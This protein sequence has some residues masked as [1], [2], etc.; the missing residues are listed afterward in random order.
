MKKMMLALWL[1]AMVVAAGCD[2][3]ISAREL[4][5]RTSGDKVNTIMW[6]YYIGSENG[7]DCFCHEMMGLSAS[8]PSPSVSHKTYYAV[9][10]SEFPTFTRRFHRTDDRTK[11]VHVMFKEDSR[12]VEILTDDGFS[13][14][15]HAPLNHV[16]ETRIERSNP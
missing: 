14:R 8:L 12:G 11:W 7:C 16:N 10:S 3:V 6:T 15:L 13:K 4:V 2:N 1:V 5:K 9:R